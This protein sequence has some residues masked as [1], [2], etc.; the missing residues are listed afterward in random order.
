MVALGANS[1]IFDP[2]NKSFDNIFTFIFC[3]NN[4]IAIETIFKVLKDKFKNNME[5]ST[6]RI[7]SLDKSMISRL[8]YDKT[9]NTLTGDKKPTGFASFCITNNQ[10]GKLVYDVSHFVKYWRTQSFDFSNYYKVEDLFI[11]QL[12]IVNEQKDD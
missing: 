12:S 6:D 8:I 10:F 11:N 9:T 5:N 3:K 4:Q 1:E 7:Y 2:V